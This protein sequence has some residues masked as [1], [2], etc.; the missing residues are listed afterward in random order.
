MKEALFRSQWLVN[1]GASAAL[2]PKR[3]EVGWLACGRSWGGK[4]IVAATGLCNNC[5]IMIIV[6]MISHHPQ[7]PATPK[8]GL[9]MVQTE[10]G[11]TGPTQ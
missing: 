11:R 4:L 10:L 6:T 3:E 1:L 8:R 7:P 5:F 2:N 9:G